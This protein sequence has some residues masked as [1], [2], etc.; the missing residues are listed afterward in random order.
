MK[1][2]KDHHM[3][4]SDAALAV[5]DTLRPLRAKGDLI[6]PGIRRGKPLSN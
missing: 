5:L 2:G 3:P 6:F 4:L 1:A